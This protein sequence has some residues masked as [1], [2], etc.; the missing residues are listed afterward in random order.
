MTLGFDDVTFTSMGTAVAET[1]L[2][3]GASLVSPDSARLLLEVIPYQN[4]LGAFTP[5]ESLMTAFRLGSDDVNLLPKRFVLPNINTGD[6]AFT[7]VQIPVLKAYTMNTP[8]NG[9]DRVNYFAQPLVAST[10]AAGCG[11]TVVYSTGA[12]GTEQFYQ[13]S[14]NETAGGTTINTRTTG[15]TITI[16]GGSEITSLYTMV[17]GGT[18]TA[19]QHDSGFMEFESSDFNT[20][21]PYRVAIQPTATG[22]GAAANALTGGNGIMEYNMP[23]GAG[24]PIAERCVINTFYTNRDART[25]GSNFIGSVRYIK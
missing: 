8:L 4:E 22:L 13:R 11:A 1:Q 18:A 3:S 10:V 20:P 21:M 17:S 19:S 7:S 12:G 14:D 25:G 16:T 23:Q 5:D 2:N 6:A 9:N 15:E 24:I